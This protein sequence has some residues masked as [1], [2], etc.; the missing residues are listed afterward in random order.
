MKSTPTLI[1]IIIVRTTSYISDGTVKHLRLFLGAFRYNFL[2]E[3]V[4]ITFI[5]FMLVAFNHRNLVTTLKL[6]VA[7]GVDELNVRFQH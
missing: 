2:S 4:N 7:W 1:I 3:N 6:P 5:Y